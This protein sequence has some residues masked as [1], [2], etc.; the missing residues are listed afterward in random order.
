MELAASGYFYA[1]ATLS[2]AFVGFTSIVVV[3]H[4]GT[5]KPLSPLHVLFTRLFAELGL[6]ATAFAMLAPTLAIIG[7]REDLVWRVSSAIMLAVSVPWLLT[8]AKRRKTAAPNERLPLRYYV[9]TILGMVAVGALCLNLIGA[10][11]NPGPGPLAI[12]TVYV[13]AY[14]TVAF[15]GTYTSFLR[16]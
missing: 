7:I 3:L 1:L 13:L 14:A 9:M 5:G 6:M 16:D 11:F 15:I 2:M 10:M 12:A 8:Y 4:Q